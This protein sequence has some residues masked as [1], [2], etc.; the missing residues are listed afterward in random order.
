M[1]T[2]TILNERVFYKQFESHSSITLDLEKTIKVIKS[3]LPFLTMFKLSIWSA[4]SGI[5]ATVTLKYGKECGEI[6]IYES[7]FFTDEHGQ[8]I[9]NNDYDISKIYEQIAPLLK[10]APNLKT[11]CI[12]A[13]IEDDY[14]NRSIDYDILSILR[15]ITF[16]TMTRSG[17]IEHNFKE[18][19]VQ[20]NKVYLPCPNCSYFYNVNKVNWYN[21][22]INL[23][24]SYPNISHIDS[25][26]EKCLDG[27]IKRKQCT[28]ENISK[29]DHYG[30]IGKLSKWN[31]LE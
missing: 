31:K 28:V 19:F 12:N 10:D 11:V 7:D 9:Y 24:N 1:E 27:Y 21:F 8:I 6:E 20:N 14:G 3:W 4:G 30:N 17:K 16:I 2:D 22:D 18:E 15:D 26:C 29:L 23:P 25:V 5:G 13:D